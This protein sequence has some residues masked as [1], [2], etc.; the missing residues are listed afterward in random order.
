M[1]SE[2]NFN[3]SQST[4]SDEQRT[5]NNHIPNRYI[6]TSTNLLAV[7]LVLLLEI[8]PI[9]GKAK[10]GINTSVEINR[11]KYCFSQKTQVFKF[12]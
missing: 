4:T 8:V 11:V 10:T 6:C 2:S 7:S 3:D 5:P 1:S 12:C 9:F